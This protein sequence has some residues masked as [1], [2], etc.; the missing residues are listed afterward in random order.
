L[1]LILP[2]IPASAHEPPTAA[3]I[4]RAR[5]AGDLQERLDFLK[6]V[7][8]QRLDA[9]LQEQ[10]QLK[11]QRAALAARGLSPQEIDQLLFGG[12]AMAFP[13]TARTELPLSGTA[14]TLTILIDF[15]DMRADA[16]LPGLTPD[17]FVANIYGAGTAEA[18]AFAPLESVNAY[19]RRASEGKVDIQGSV[20]GWHHLPQARSTYAPLSATPQARNRAPFRIAAEA[21][22]AFDADHDFAQYDHDHDGD[23]DQV[24][25]LYAGPHTGWGSFFWAYKW[26]FFVPEA[27]TQTFDNKRLNQFVFQF[28]SR[29]G[30]GNQDF[31]PQTLIH[32]MGHSFGL[33]DYYDYDRSTGPG[34]GLGGMDMMDANVGNHNAFSRWL[35]DWIRPE[36]IG[37][38]PP[39]SRVL[40]AS[41]SGQA[42]PKALA[43]F[44][45]LANATAP[46]SEMFIVENRFQTGNDRNLPG[47]GLLIWHVDARPNALDNNF[48]MDN[49]YTDHK[50]I[51]LVRADHPGD[52]GDGEQGGSATFFRAPLAFGPNTNPG[53]VDSVGRPTG[54][55][56]AS[57]SSAAETVSV[58]AGIVPIAGGAPALAGAAVVANAG[59]STTPAELG[60]AIGEI[61]RPAVA[62]PAGPVPAAAP[63]LSPAQAPPGVADQINELA[64]MLDTATPEAIQAAL[65]DQAEG[66]AAAAAP[67]PPVGVGM[68]PPPAA[69]PGE[70]VSQLMLT[71]LAAKDG[72]AAVEAVL[73][74]PKGDLR[75]RTFTSVLE[76]WAHNNPNEAARWYFGPKGAPY[77]ASNDLVAGPRF[78]YRITRRAAANNL[79][80]AITSVAAL[81]HPTEIWGAVD[82]IRQAAD[83][84]PA[85]EDE[86]FGKLEANE[87]QRATIRTIRQALAVRRQLDESG[88]APAAKEDFRNLINRELSVSP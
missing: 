24:T 49:S 27:A 36:V 51:R 44:P 16:L 68:A 62:V 12:V 2:R 75:S 1:A 5:Q 15:A 57:L 83:L 35:L 47:N 39:S 33:A 6:Q 26:N 45:G 77:R 72:P 48:Q 53:S 76:A 40:V 88:L 43:I 13:Y 28:V 69:P 34:G 65:N 25:F 38:N 20:L 67:A 78:A 32:E 52:F 55:M 17:R 84:V 8:N 85:P 81:A 21:L 14:R 9:S 41:A 30:P 22:A 64:A 60:R 23:I 66:L 31:N 29:R 82:A 54:V 56:I 70:L 80:E 19:Y 11:L 73:A 4:E 87:E 79:D 59:D 61:I 37:A 74:L 42:G 18:Q 50:L 46:G 86:V 7:E 10:A 3:D 71:R 58:S 63:G